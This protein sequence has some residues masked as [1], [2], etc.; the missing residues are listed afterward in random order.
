MKTSIPNEEK[1]FHSFENTIGKNPWKPYWDFS[2]WLHYETFSRNIARHLKAACRVVQNKRIFVIVRYKKLS[3]LHGINRSH[4]HSISGT[5]F[6]PCDPLVFPR[7]QG[8][9]KFRIRIGLPIFIRITWSTIRTVKADLR[10]ASFHLLSCFAA[11]RHS[12][13]SS[14][15]SCSGCVLVC[16]WSSGRRTFAGCWLMRSFFRWHAL[17]SKGGRAVSVWGPRFPFRRQDVVFV[18]HFGFYMNALSTRRKKSLLFFVVSVWMYRS[19]VPNSA[20]RTYST[21]IHSCIFRK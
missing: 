1:S 19:A 18:H 5:C 10:Q 11:H 9:P 16:C 8:L 17:H 6:K 13:L 12:S 21:D 2:P 14:H 3:P 15:N 4:S 7:Q 20:R